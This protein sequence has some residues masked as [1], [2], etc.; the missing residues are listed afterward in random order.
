MHGATIERAPTHHNCSSSFN[1]P[2]HTSDSNSTN[3]IG[4]TIKLSIKCIDPKPHF[5]DGKIF[6]P[7]V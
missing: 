6:Q 1:P 3:K 7:Q 4:D 2:N 5:Q